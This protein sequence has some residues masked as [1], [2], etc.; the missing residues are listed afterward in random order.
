M[1]DMKKRILSLLLAIVMVVS[2]IP[3]TAFAVADTQGASAE[4][5][6]PFADVKETDWFYD[7]VQYARVNGFSVAPA[8]RPL[9]P[10]GP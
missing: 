1:H 6:N 3:T 10:T 4:Q 9:N 8:R 5:A 2:L 7:A